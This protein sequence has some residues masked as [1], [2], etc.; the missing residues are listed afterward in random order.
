MLEDLLFRFAATQ[1]SLA[2]K[3]KGCPG[4]SRLERGNTI[5]VG[6]VKICL[7][8]T[9][10]AGGA[11]NLGACIVGVECGDGSKAVTMDEES[12]DMEIKTGRALGSKAD[13]PT[14]CSFIIVLLQ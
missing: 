1:S 7:T 2:K 11:L 13:R 4:A 6:M 9:W 3:E 8:G 14:K 10:V 5:R 12:C